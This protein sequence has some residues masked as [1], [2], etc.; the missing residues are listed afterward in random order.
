RNKHR[1]RLPAPATWVVRF[2]GEE[3]YTVRFDG[4]RWS[5]ERGAAD[6]PDVVVEATPETFVNFLIADPAD[7]PAQATNLTITGDPEQVAA[8]RASYGLQDTAHPTPA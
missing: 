8:F 6:H 5:Y 1:V 4:D 3:S 2:I 7:R